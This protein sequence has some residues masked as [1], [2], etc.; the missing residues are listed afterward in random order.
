MRRK[1][2]S[3]EDG[4][5]TVVCF[6]PQHHHVECLARTLESLTDATELP[7]QVNVVV[8]GHWRSLR[9]RGQELPFSADYPFDLSYTFNEVDFGDADVMGRTLADCPSRYWAFVSHDVILPHGGIDVMLRCLRNEERRKDHKVLGAAMACVDAEDEPPV[10]LDA[11][12]GVLRLIP[13]PRCFREEE[14]AVWEVCD[15]VGYGPLVLFK[16]RVD[17]AAVVFDRDFGASGHWLDFSMQLHERELRLVRV[18]QPATQMHIGCVDDDHET[19]LMP[20]GDAPLFF[21]KWKDV[22]VRIVAEGEEI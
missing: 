22:C 13:E 21:S 20:V 15:H 14:F 17:S 1:Q 8:Q 16:P 6:R 4:V 12:G 9:R 7:H 5:T 3:A 10:T 18:R 11:C 19:A 2:R